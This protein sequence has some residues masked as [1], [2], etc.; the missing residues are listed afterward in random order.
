MTA[1]A[2]VVKARESAELVATFVEKCA[3]DLERAARA[4]AD[5]FRRGGRL[6]T[7]GNGGLAK[8]G[9][10]SMTL[11]TANPYRGGTTVAA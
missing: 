2:M 5:R 10:G 1:A 7:M 4:L 11:G 8:T 3:P 6:F 9:L